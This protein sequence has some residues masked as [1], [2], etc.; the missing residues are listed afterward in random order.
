MML[1]DSVSP[2]KMLTYTDDG[3]VCKPGMRI[4]IRVEACME[5]ARSMPV[6]LALASGQCTLLLL[7][8]PTTTRVSPCT[9]TDCAIRTCLRGCEA[10]LETFFCEAPM[11][12]ACDLMADYPGAWTPWVRGPIG[13]NWSNQFKACPESY[14]FPLPG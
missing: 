8:P 14:T 5:I 10:Q 11:D 2:H 3:D 6:D 7:V 13:N 1:P 9:Q 4:H 12:S